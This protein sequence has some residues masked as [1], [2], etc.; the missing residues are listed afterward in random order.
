[1][2]GRKK[3]EGTGEPPAVVAAPGGG[4]DAVLRYLDRKKVDIDRIY[5]L[6]QGSGIRT[7]AIVSSLTKTFEMPRSEFDDD[8]PG[9]DMHPEQEWT[10]QGD[11]DAGD[12]SRFAATFVLYLDEMLQPPAPGDEVFVYFAPNDRTQVLADELWDPKMPG[13]QPGFGHDPIRWK[14]PAECPNCGARVDQSTESLA[15]HPTCH[16]CNAPLPCE[17]T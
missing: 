13:N 2:F 4:K 12:G 9:L 14:V 15:E 16:M 11:I 5:A 3:K 6:Q 7:K 1:M 8:I 10:I 17:P